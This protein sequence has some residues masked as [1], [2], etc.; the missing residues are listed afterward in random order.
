MLEVRIFNLEDPDESPTVLE[1]IDYVSLVS[2]STYGPPPCIAPTK[3]RQAPLARP[4]DVVLYINPRANP[5][6]SI[7]RID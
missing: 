7:E 3:D 2:D 4:G 1:D 6:F 5:L